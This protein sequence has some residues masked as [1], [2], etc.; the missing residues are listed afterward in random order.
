MNSR[1]NQGLSL[2]ELFL[3]LQICKH[4]QFT[5]IGA[6]LMN[7]LELLLLGHGWGLLMFL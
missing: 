3:C 7:R 2:Q 6:Q 5:V 4:K 1:G